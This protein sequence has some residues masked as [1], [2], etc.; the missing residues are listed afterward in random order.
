MHPAGGPTASS[1]RG[2][3]TCW[4]S[5][6]GRT[7]RRSRWSA[8]TRCPS[9]WSARCG[10]RCRPRPGQPARFDYEYTR[11]GTANLFMISEPL[12]GW[13]HVRVTERRTAMDFAEVLRWLVEDVHPDA[14]KVVLVMDNLN[15]HKLGVA[16]RGVPAGAGA[17]D[18]R[19]AGVALHAEARVMAE[20]G[21]DRVGGAVGPVP[22]PAD[23]VGGSIKGSRGGVGRGTER[24]A[25]WGG[26]AVHH[27]RRPDQAPPTLPRTTNEMTH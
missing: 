3:R 5:T 13:R 15:T 26:L 20:R 9:N 1:W 21:R 17:A 22:G 7:T 10:C 19:E 23:R 8:S 2:W 24:T 18:R 11:N 12:L 4:R 27:R 6:T 14:E 25:D 16:V